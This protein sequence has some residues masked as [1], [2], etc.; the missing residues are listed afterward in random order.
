MANEDLVDYETLSPQDKQV[1][2]AL[3]VRRHGGMALPATPLTSTQNLALQGSVMRDPYAPIQHIPGE[4]LRAGM[5]A[6]QQNIANVPMRVAQAMGARPG[7]MGELAG[8]AGSGLL[9]FATA[10][11]GTPEGTAVAAAMGPLRAGAQMLPKLPM[12][13][14]LQMGGLAAA[15]GATA[16][17]TGGNILGGTVEG[18][19]AGAIGGIF[20][21]VSDRLAQKKEDAL[22]LGKAIV[23]E[24][25]WLKDLIPQTGAAR[26]EIGP[27]LAIRDPKVGQALLST[28]FEQ[29]KQEIIATVGKDTPI[30]IP[31]LDGGGAAAIAKRIS[32]VTGG[33]MDAE[34]AQAMYNAATE[35]GMLQPKT[36]TIESA[37]RD[38]LQAK[39]L[40]RKAP[41]GAI[42]WT[43]RER[44]RQIQEE[45]N[46]TIG[47]SDAVNAKVGKSAGN[48][49]PRYEDAMRQYGK[50]M[51]I[52]DI[53][54]DSE[55]LQLTR[56]GGQ[57]DLGKLAQYLGKNIDEY[58]PT[59]FP[60]LYR[61]ATRTAPLGSSDVPTTLR[62]PRLY[63]HGL[64]EGAPVLKFKGSTGTLG[65]PTMGKPSAGMLPADVG[66]MSPEWALQQPPQGSQ[67]PLG[68]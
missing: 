59:S 30:E 21:R 63:G 68:Q 55:T 3:A 6:A 53:L 62:L 17:L 52:F 7:G 27:L 40:A 57:V 67:I 28:K 48:L 33:R 10:P 36:M 9:N 20:K 15:G 16:G 1:F 31:A 22:N 38:L 51:A 60:N 65:A 39:A 50:G 12:P 23:A 58:G 44:A 45:I 8:M 24:V 4:G 19:G 32:T 56:K 49:L 35:L 5:A 25:P 34:T 2:D 54:G 26:G 37:F 64:S 46:S 66:L 61:A 13:N 11:F 42:G 41:D 29:I 47:I 18:V 43:A 14:L